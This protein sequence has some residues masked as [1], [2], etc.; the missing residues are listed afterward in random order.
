MK[1][2]K[3]L[4]VDDL[5]RGFYPHVYPEFQN[6]WKFLA[7]DFEQLKSDTKVQQVYSNRN[8]EVFVIS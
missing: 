5:G 3:Y 8:L 6:N 4:L 1:N 7:Q 2:S